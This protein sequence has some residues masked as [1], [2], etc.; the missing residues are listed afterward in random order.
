MPGDGLRGTEMGQLPEQ[1]FGI[2]MSRYRGAAGLTQEDLAQRS[3]LSVGAISLLERG[4]R[5]APRSPTVERL[6]TALGLGPRD[7]QALTAAPPARPGGA[8]RLRPPARPRAPPPRP[9][10]PGP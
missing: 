8:P 3:G 6:V 1:T 10:P 9:V 5:T 7:R 2:L 4:L